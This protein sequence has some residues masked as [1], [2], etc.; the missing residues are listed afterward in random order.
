M[1]SAE[2]FDWKARRVL[3]TGADGF[4]GGWLVKAL[5]ARGAAVCGLTGPKSPVAA[6]PSRR[7]QMPVPAQVKFVRGSIV[8]IREMSRLVA[9]LCI[10]TVFHLAATNINTGAGI[11]PYRVFETNIRGAYTVL[12]ACRL[13]PQPV[14]A[15]LASSKEVEACFLPAAERAYHPYMVSKAAAEL[16]AR[17]YRDTFR[18]PV[19]VARS[20]NIYGGGDFNWSRLIPGVIRAI[21]RGERPVIRSDGSFARDYVYIDDAVAAY[22]AIGGRLHGPPSNTRLFR[23]AT[24][25]QTSVLDVVGKLLRAAGRPDLTPRVL[26]QATEERTDGPYRPD[27]E[28][29][30]LGWKSRVGVEEGLSQTWQWYRGFFERDAAS[31]KRRTRRGS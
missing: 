23:I 24:G 25:R 27:M 5:V 26:N 20:D 18:V 21:A 17:G 31:A 6:R 10:D 4:V 16:A 28:R 15:V 14:R 29:K 19:A 1:N 22:L 30:E 13:A 9:D 11:S 12:E 7:H 2:P 3:V 8:S